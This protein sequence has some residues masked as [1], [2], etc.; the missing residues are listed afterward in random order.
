M[1]AGFVMRRTH[2]PRFITNYCI[3]CLCYGTGACDIW[4]RQA[5]RK[6]L[7]VMSVGTVVVLAVFSALW[8]HGLIGQLHSEVS[9]IRYLVLSLGLVAIGAYRFTRRKKD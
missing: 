3:E 8:I 9:I 5:G 7:F 2:L 1:G 4:T 6:E